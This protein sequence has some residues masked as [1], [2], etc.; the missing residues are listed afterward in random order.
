M[1]TLSCKNEKIEVSG[2]VLSEWENNLFLTVVL[3]FENDSENEKYTYPIN[4]DI[5]YLLNELVQFFKENKI[6]YEADAKISEYLEVIH[7]EQVDYEAIKSLAGE[8]HS[9]LLPTRFVRQLK[10]Y[11]EQGFYH[12]ISHKNAA[13]FSVPGSGKTSVVYAAYSYLKEKAVVDKLIVVGP[14]SSFLPWEEEAIGCFGEPIITARLSGE[15]PVRDSI[16]L[17]A[18]KYEL[19]LCTYQTATNDIYELSRM[20]AKYKFMMVVD[21]V[22]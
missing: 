9:V 22:S 21:R 7:N 13:N 11:Q 1:I 8:T 19:F 18:E 4:E 16:Y 15:K 12:L 2:E 10:S 14:R 6:E 3:D 20:L 5:Y 17:L